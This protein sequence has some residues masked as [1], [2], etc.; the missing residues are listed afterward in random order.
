MCEAGVCQPVALTTSN[1]MDRQPTDIK[2]DDASV[3][4][5]EPF[6]AGSVYKADKNGDNPLVLFDNTAASNVVE[7]PYSLA[8]DSTNLYIS[9]HATG[10][11]YACAVGGCGGNPTNIGTLNAG[12]NFAP[13]IAVGGSY[14]YATDTGGSVWRAL[15]N[16][17]AA[18]QQLVTYMPALPDAGGGGFSNPVGIALDTAWAYFTNY[19]GTVQKVALDGGAN[20]QLGAGPQ[21]EPGGIWVSNGN[22]Y[23]TQW[24]D[25]GGTVASVST[26]GGAVNVLQG[27]QHTPYAVTADGTNLYWVTQGSAPNYNN[28]TVM[29]C[30][31]TNCTNPI[32][33]ASGQLTPN[34]IAVDDQAV[35][36]VNYCFFQPSPTSSG[37]V[38]KVA[39]P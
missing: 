7:L 16:G 25:P 9:D 35:Y 34:A 1:G 13:Y 37:G 28:G 29:M 20:M 32:T 3:Y 36:W 17:T 10:Y 31:I 33:L 30:P 11:I 24:A 39:K 6:S 2:V 21:M 18:F 4:W 12:N 22:V 19:D 15:T 23:F 14:I 5:V 27:S 8:L 38:Y 26:G